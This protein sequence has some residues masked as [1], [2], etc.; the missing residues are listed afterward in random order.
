MDRIESYL[1]SVRKSLDL[2]TDAESDAVIAEIRDHILE[3]VERLEN[4]GLDRQS[5]IER[6]VEQVGDRHVVAAAVSRSPFLF[7]PKFI[8]YILCFI[9]PAVG[10]SLLFPAYAPGIALTAGI[11][12]FLVSGFVVGVWWSDPAFT[13]EA[14][15]QIRYF[16][17]TILVVIPASSRIWDAL[18]GER[19]WRHVV[20]SLLI[21]SA[22]LALSLG[23]FYLGRTVDRKRARVRD[24]SQKE[25]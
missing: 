22:L 21:Y 9:L 19:E 12:L 24:P 3:S 11:L 10:F 20:V 18:R 16:V 25:S 6:A 15:R 14:R 23:G 7:I 4:E 17:L 8:G 2:R 13:D 1:D 5:A